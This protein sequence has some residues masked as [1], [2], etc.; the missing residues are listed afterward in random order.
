MQVAGIGTHSAL[1]ANKLT[2]GN[3]SVNGKRAGY[4]SHMYI[5]ADDARI[6]AVDRNGTCACTVDIFYD[7]IKQAVDR[8][9]VVIIDI[10]A[11]MDKFC[12]GH[13]LPAALPQGGCVFSFSHSQK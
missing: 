2:G 6:L 12:T 7:A 9:P 4:V 10:H 3:L 8:C 11:G 5:I 1:G 13:S